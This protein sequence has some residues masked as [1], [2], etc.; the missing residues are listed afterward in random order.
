MLRDTPCIREQTLEV[1]GARVEF[2]LAKE[3]TK[4]SILSLHVLLG[5]IV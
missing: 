5:L 1:D 4:A 2:S 3:G